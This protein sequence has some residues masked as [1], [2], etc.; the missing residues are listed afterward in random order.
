MSTTD[1]AKSDAF[2]VDAL[3]WRSNPDPLV[4]HQ[5]ID[6]NLLAQ[7][8][9]LVRSLTP[10]HEDLSIIDFEKLI[11]RKTELVTLLFVGDDLRGTAQA[12]LIRPAGVRT[13][14]IEKVVVH[15]DYR[16]RGLGRLLM[17]QTEQYSRSRFSKDP[18]LRICLTS[19]AEHGTKEFYERLGFTGTPTIRYQK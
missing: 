4:G 18:G 11:A 16:G 15:I 8:N 1:T 10:Q 3:W 5:G 2:V 19:R 7:Y 13:V 9:A 17:E 12:S 6:N 14:W